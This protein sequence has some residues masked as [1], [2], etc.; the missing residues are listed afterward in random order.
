MSISSALHLKE[1]WNFV[2]SDS[3][4]IKSQSFIV[5]IKISTPSSACF[6]FSPLFPFLSLFT[7]FQSLWPLCSSSN[8]S[9]KP[10]GYWSFPTWSSP[11]DFR[12]ADFLTQK[13]PS[14][15]GLSWPLYLKQQFSPYT[16]HP[17]NPHLLYHAFLLSTAIFSVSCLYKLLICY[18]IYFLFPLL[19][20]KLPE[21]RNLC[22]IH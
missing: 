20:Y 14:L 13:L 8:T 5:P 10:C 16:S 1:T 18:I 17:Y 21:A 6:L 12:V 4:Q 7:P 3:R 11:P 22:L 19:D 9:S 2:K 15:C